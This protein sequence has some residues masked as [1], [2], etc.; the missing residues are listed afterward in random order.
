MSDFL[1]F[2][3]AHGLQIGRLYPSDRVQ[4]CATVEKP[5]SKNGAYFYDGDRGWVSDW[6]Q[7]GEINW[8][9]GGKSREFTS[10]DRQAW[11]QRKQMFETRQEQGW[12]NAA[13]AAA[14]ILR[15]TTPKEHNY[16]HMKGLP[17][18]HG[19]VDIEENL[20]VP[21]RNL[22]TNELQGVQIIKWLPDEMRYEKKM[23][24]G[25]RAK[26]AVLR[27][28]SRQAFETILCEGYGTGLSLEL[29]ARLMRLN[30]C[31][32]VSFS[33]SNMVFVA[34]S[35]KGRVYVYADNDKSGAG[36]RAAKKTGF[37]Y[38]MSDVIGND[39][40]DDHKQFGLMAV[41]QK[42]LQVR[43]LEPHPT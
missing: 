11:A 37:S 16:L 19:L 36:L 38:C 25:M 4:R 30:A 20:I 14:V 3:T 17:D 41:A 22:K 31:V 12:R 27:I 43:R 23:L 39:A 40:N 5:R 21:M 8:F 26:G 15:G 24:P 35:L 2:A 6:A 13:L 18:L 10:Q 32:M 1:S 28:G 9:D 33:D 34:A 29:A 7:G 42:L